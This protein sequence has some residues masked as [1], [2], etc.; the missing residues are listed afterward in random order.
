M[1]TVTVTPANGYSRRGMSGY[2]A[3]GAA[4]GPWTPAS[5]FSSGIN[6]DW[7]VVGDR[8]TLRQ[9]TTDPSANVNLTNDPVGRWIGK[10]NLLNLDQATAG[11]KPHYNATENSV[12]FPDG[13]GVRFLEHAIASAWPTGHAVS[14]FCTSRSSVAPN[15]VAGDNSRMQC[16][17]GNFSTNNQRGAILSPHGGADGS[18]QG[19][20]HSTVGAAT[21]TAPTGVGSTVRRT[22]ACVKKGDGTI[23][24]Y[25]V[26][27]AVKNAGPAGGS[28]ANLGSAA[29]DAIRMISPEGYAAVPTFHVFD[30][31]VVHREAS[32]QDFLNYATYGASL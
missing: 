25:T 22:S 28:T 21:L 14:V 4:A 31:V 6:G 32:L 3:V 11:T 9:N 8:A 2:R 12:A 13:T 10:I 16:G 26:N 17:P 24:N 23:V 20:A 19:G 15:V 29:G 5:L 7:W 1:G 18:D 30:F 27:G